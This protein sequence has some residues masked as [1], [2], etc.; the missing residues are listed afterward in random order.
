MASGHGDGV[1]RIWNM[2][3]GENV[4]V[5]HGHTG[6]VYDLAFSPD[7]RFLAS[8]SRWA[9]LWDLNATQPGS[10]RVPTA[11]VHS[12]TFTSDG[13][14]LLCGYSNGI[15]LFEVRTWREVDY[16]PM[17]R[18]MRVPS[19]ALSRDGGVLAAAAHDGM[20][21]LWRRQDAPEP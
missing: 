4:R 18:A 17:R 21:H 15:R 19:M 6:W 7:G 10:S 20:I 1:V 11:N 16:L 2:A 5:L 3:T 13:R 8:C 14:G 9:L 12:V